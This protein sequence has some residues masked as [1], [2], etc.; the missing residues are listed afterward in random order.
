MFRPVT[1]DVAALSGFVAKGHQAMHFV[2]SAPSK[3][4]YGGFSP[5]RL[6]TSLR[7]NHL[8]RSLDLPIG[9]HCLGWSTFGVYP[10]FKRDQGY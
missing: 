2:S 3:I 1:S 7:R 8:H 6:Q 10:A 9:C 4:P 5:V